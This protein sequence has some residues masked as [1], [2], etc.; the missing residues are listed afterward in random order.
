MLAVDRPGSDDRE[1]PAVPDASRPEAAGSRPDRGAVLTDAGLRQEHA[2]AYR[3]KVD[4]TYRAAEEPTGR[5]EATDQ[6]ERADSAE[7]VARPDNI[8]DTV[9]VPVVYPD[10]Y[11]PWAGPQRI[12]EQREA[13]DQ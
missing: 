5:K 4:V 9:D 10:D 6:E 13:L 11:V 3:A 8:Y 2:L 12:V 1:V 7:P